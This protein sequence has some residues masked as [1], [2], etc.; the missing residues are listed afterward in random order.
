MARKHKISVRKVLQALITLVV[1][2]ACI[3]GVSDASRKQQTQTLAAISLYITNEQQY[4]FL[5]KQVLSEEIITQHAL[6]TGRTPLGRLYLDEIETLILENPWVAGAEVY[7]DN[8]RE[9]HLNVTQRVPVA[10]V[11][12]ENGESFYLDTALNLLPLSDKFSYYTTVVTNVP[13]FNHDSLNHVLRTQIV[14]L[15]QFVDNDTFWRAQLAQISV[16]PD[17]TFELYPVLG[18]HKILFGDTTRMLQKFETLFGFYKQVLNDI[19]WNRYHTLDLRY[20]G[21]LVALP[22]LPRTRLPK[23]GVSNMNWLNSIMEEAGKKSTV[24][25]G[26]GTTSPAPVATTAVPDPVPQPGGKTVIKKT[27]PPAA[28]AAKQQEAGTLQTNR[29]ELPKANNN[30]EQKPKYLYQ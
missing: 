16:T 23:N 18:T 8:R 15:V 10:R 11:F 7:I 5:D 1:A 17:A 26:A 22:A 3:A 25:P 9:L 19:G 20:R 2:V 29:Q 30:N 27:I 28:A 21:Q 4:Q 24:Q 6:V 12:F 13:W 14:H